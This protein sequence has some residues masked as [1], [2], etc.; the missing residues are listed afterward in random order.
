MW[1]LVYTYTYI[2]TSANSYSP[3]QLQ[4]HSSRQDGC[5]LA[6]VAGSCHPGLRSPLQLYAL[7]EAAIFSLNV[8]QYFPGTRYRGLVEAT[9]PGIRSADALHIGMPTECQLN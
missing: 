3:I 2:V 9:W 6:L 5:I 8:A 4:P 7:Y 1:L